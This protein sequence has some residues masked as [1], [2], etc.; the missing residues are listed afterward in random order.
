MEADGESNEISSIPEGVD[1]LECSI[2][3]QNRNLVCNHHNDD[4]WLR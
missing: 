4:S 1:N 2:L 3:M